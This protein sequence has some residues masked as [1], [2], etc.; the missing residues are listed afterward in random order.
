[1]RAEPAH[2]GALLSLGNLLCAERRDYDGAEHCFRA[3]LAATGQQ[4]AIAHFNL[5]T[6][7]H[8]HRA[9]FVAA[10]ASYGAALA[11]DPADGCGIGGSVHC[12]LGILA[13]E[14]LDLDGAERAYDLATKADP[15]SAL[16]W[17]NLGHLLLKHRSSPALAGRCFHRYVE[18]APSEPNAHNSLG[19]ALRTAGDLDGAEVCFCHALTIDPHDAFARKQLAALRCNALARPAFFKA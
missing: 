15:A 10:R 11:C 8:K 18:L 6:V 3:V 14:Q 4:H 7:L 1:L 13:E 2:A 17:C 12:A 5:G 19:S 16:A 9:D